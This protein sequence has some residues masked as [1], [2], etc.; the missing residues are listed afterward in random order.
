MTTSPDRFSTQAYDLGEI[1]S[2]ARPT[3][4]WEEVLTCPLCRCAA[5]EAEIFEQVVSSGYRLTYLICPRCGLVFQSPR[6]SDKMLERY[7]Q[8]GYRRQVQGQES[9][10]AKDRWAQ[11]NRARE[12]LAFITPH[13]PR[14][15]RHLDIGSSLGELLLAFSEF[16]GC[17][18]IGAEPGVAY[19]AYSRERGL[20]V[21][22]SLSDLDSGLRH[23]FD[24]LSLI[25]VLEH[26]PDPVGYLRRLRSDW[27][28]RDGWLLVE[29][30]NLLGHPSLEL[31]H[32]TAYTPSTL[33]SALETAGFEVV[34]LRRHGR[35]YSRLL[36]TLVSAL[37]RPSANEPTMSFRRGFAIKFRRRIG[38]GLLMSARAIARALL[39]KGQLA[40]WE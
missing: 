19:R 31:A 5:E 17:V 36:K 28:A 39:R 29:V 20:T 40:P 30:P 3:E 34:E 21:V 4:D 16:Y 35:P 15:E 2:S 8:E 11:A 24:L 37:A 38:L 12:L 27:M 25:H 10:S 26:L 18:P 22:G 33:K 1:G 14:V 9:P 32:L 6:L 23:S 13:V 7:Y